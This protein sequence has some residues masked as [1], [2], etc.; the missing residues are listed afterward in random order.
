MFIIFLGKS[1]GRIKQLD[2]RRDPLRYYLAIGAFSGLIS[3]TV[4]SIFDFNLQIPANCLYFIVLLAVLSVCTQQP[5]LSSTLNH[6][7][8][9]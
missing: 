7:I 2:F 6:R 1:A 4:H 5:K 9:K 8:L 3:M